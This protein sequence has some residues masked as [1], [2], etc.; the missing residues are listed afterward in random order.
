[1]SN[2]I[3]ETSTATLHMIEEDVLC[4]RFKPYMMLD[5]NHLYEN[6]EAIYS[7][8][9]ENLVYVVSV[10]YEDTLMTKEFRELFTKKSIRNFKKGEA[11]VINTL[12]QHLLAQHVQ[13]TKN[14]D[15]PLQFVSNETE[16]LEWISSLKKL[17]FTKSNDY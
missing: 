13:K 5:L 10:P 17:E 2:K 3:I 16:A 6:R 7:L 14:S 11:V 9:G 12:A 15:Y 1:M 4:I 8:I